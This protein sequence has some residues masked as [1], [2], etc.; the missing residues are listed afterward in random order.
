MNAAPQSNAAPDRGTRR[1]W[2]KSVLSA[3]ATAI[4]FVVVALLGLITSLAGVGAALLAVALV[5]VLLILGVLALA[6]L[7]QLFGWV[8]SG[9]GLGML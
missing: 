1:P 7:I 5:P 9:L 2:W 4:M 8:L 3:V 6:L